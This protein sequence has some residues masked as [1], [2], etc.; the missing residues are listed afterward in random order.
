MELFG[1][2]LVADIKDQRSKKEDI[3]PLNFTTYGI[4]GKLA[5]YTR[6]D[7]V[8]C[9]DGLGKTHHSPIRSNTDI[10]IVGDENPLNRKTKKL[11][12][13]EKYDIR[14]VSESEIGDW[15]ANNIL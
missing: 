15:L 4:T 6:V 1:D 7:L 9:L 3:I 13:A 10:L 5:D 14:I 12:Q 2:S 11:S 8:T